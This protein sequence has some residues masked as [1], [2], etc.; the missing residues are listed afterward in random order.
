MM[1]ENANL[2]I[3]KKSL[4]EELAEQLQNQIKDGKFAVGQKL[5]TEPELMLIFGVGR[6]TV[7]EAVKILVNMG[8]LKVQQGAGTFVENLTASNEPMEQ[9]LRRADIHDLDEVRK[10]LEIAIAGRAAERRT[11][12]DIEKIE[13]FLDER[14]RTAEAGQLEACIEADVNFHIA[15]A[16]AT[17][18]EILYE[19]YRSAAIYLRKGFEHIYVDT[20]C[21][22]AS[23]PTHKQL[24]RH[25][26]AQDAREALHTINIILQ[27]P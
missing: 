17:H 22:L 8:F 20:A 24:V 11:E 4:A 13:G 26:I 21:F 3:Q 19:L 1:K 16:K 9:R 25:I 10:I 7:R 2:V 27:E 12:Q 14:G 23:Q 18:N 15:L 5:P 6:S